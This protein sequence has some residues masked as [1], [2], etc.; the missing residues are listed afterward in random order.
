MGGWDAV[1]GT[2]TLSCRQNI[3]TL[4]PEGQTPGG[5]GPKA[6]ALVAFFKSKSR[7][8]G[9]AEADAAPLRSPRSFEN[10]L[11]TIREKKPSDLCLES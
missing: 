5:E 6:T 4:F 11:S 3:L 1:L 10:E 8:L 2:G 7:S 9:R